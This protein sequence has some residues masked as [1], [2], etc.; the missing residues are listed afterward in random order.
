MEY[1]VLGPLEVID[2]QRDLTPGAAKQCVIL[3]LLALRKNRTVQTAAII[4]ELWGERPPDTAH[5]TLQTY[6]YKLR[7]MIDT[8]GPGEGRKILLN[9]GYGYQ[10]TVHGW[11]NDLVRFEKFEEEGRQ[12]M[13]ASRYEQA[14][15][16]FNQALALFRGPV[17]AN[18]PAGNRIAAEVARLEERRMRTL[19]M[20]LDVDL[21]LGNHHALISELKALIMTYPMNEAFYG[22][23]M[24]ALAACGRSNEALDVYGQLRIVLKEELGID[25][26]PELRALH[27]EI[28]ASH[29]VPGGR[30]RTAAVTAVEP[31]LGCPAQL[32]PDHLDFTGRE[33]LVHDLGQRLVP[34][35]RHSAAN[36]IVSLT[37]MPG[38]G[39]TTLAVHL[40]HRVRKWFPDGQLFADLR[41]TDSVS[42]EPYELLLGFLR[43]VGPVP[44][45]AANPNL[46]LAQ[47]GRLFRAW[48]AERRVLIVLDDAASAWQVE[49]LMPGNPRCGVIVTSR[50]VHGFPGA[51][52]AQVPPMQV[53]ESLRLLASLIGRRRIDSETDA[54]VE[55]VRLAGHLPLAIRAAGTRLAAA[56]SLALSRFARQ[57]AAASERLGELST[58][59][60][61]L[62]TRYDTSYERLEEREKWAFRLLS[63]VGDRTF[64][65]GDIVE[66]LGCPPLMVE[67]VLARL[68]EYHFLTLADT[69]DGQ[70]PHYTF[71]G[72]TRFYAEEQLAK[73][74]TG[75]DLRTSRPP[76]GARDLTGSDLV[77]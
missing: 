10:L 52:T 9:K 25:P 33:E 46:D 51:H 6:I 64:A 69:R 60:I 14:Q 44:G 38:V 18:V 31:P 45:D 37:G 66:L 55:T 54:A 70:V 68:V 77:R 21:E 62:R 5:A 63:L 65:S 34:P 13:K 43:E 32:P 72:L 8:C 22:R 30:L 20:R 56:P 15:K 75:D 48:C 3:A 27:R 61:D 23:L 2:G 42:V 35:D 17:L 24:T 50:F 4:D 40:A 39:K 59:D 11:Q 49:P 41:G 26:S 74:A 28:L 7:K 73:V 67:M 29:P 53:R 19:E 71:P 57:L 12:A 1:R 76:V 36:R 16:A 58:G 47:A